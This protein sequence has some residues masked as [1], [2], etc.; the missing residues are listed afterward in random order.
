MFFLIYFCC[1]CCLLLF[2]SKVESARESGAL[3]TAMASAAAEASAEAA[4]LR[5]E[6]AAL[7]AAGAEA[8]AAWGRRWEAL[9]AHQQAADHSHTPLAPC[10]LGN[11]SQWLASEQRLPRKGVLD[12]LSY[13]LTAC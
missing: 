2:W 6:G 13:A 12:A 5:A 10:P 9:P 11:I 4:G 7:R 1:C 3:R 8:E